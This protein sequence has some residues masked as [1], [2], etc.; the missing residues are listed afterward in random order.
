[1]S[2]QT[3]SDYLASIPD[4]AA[5]KKLALMLSADFYGIRIA[6]APPK[7]EGSWRTRLPAWMAQ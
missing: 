3:E 7:D 6:E 4:R 5:Q 2:K 1:M